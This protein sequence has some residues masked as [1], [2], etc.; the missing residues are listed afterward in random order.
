MMNVVLSAG[1]SLTYTVEFTTDD[2]L[3]EGILNEAALSW[4]PVAGL[5][6]KSASAQ[7]NLVVPVTAIRLRVSTYTSGSATL[8]MIQAG[9]AE[10]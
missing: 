7:S 6:A 10:K 2:V 8:T 9:I 3:V 5:D 1:A 4:F